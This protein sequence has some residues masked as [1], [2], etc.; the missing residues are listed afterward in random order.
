M[1]AQ[2]RALEGDIQS[3][4]NAVPTIISGSTEESARVLV[5]QAEKLAQILKSGQ[6]TQIRAIF[7]EL[8]HI[9]N[10]WMRKQTALAIRRLHLLQPKLKYRASR[11]SG[12]EP[13]ADVLS[14]AV[15]YVVETQSDDEKLKM[16]RH[17]VEFAEAVLAYYKFEEEEKEEKDKKRG[18]E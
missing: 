16:F 5:Q 9:E 15:K 1:K 6:M 12:L 18:G 8:R 10:L 3:I 17:L 13:L 4:L 14:C 7:D 11:K 2:S